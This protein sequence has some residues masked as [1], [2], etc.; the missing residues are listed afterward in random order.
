MKKRQFKKDMPREEQEK[1]QGEDQRMWKEY[2]EE[3]RS[4][5]DSN[6]SEMAK[7]GEK[8]KEQGRYQEGKQTEQYDTKA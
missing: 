3:L 8:I 6:D 4:S 7:G 2:F 1:R 5:N